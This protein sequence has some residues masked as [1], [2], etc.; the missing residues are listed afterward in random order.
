MPQDRDLALGRGAPASEAQQGLDVG[1]DSRA[2]AVGLELSNST[3]LYRV[4]GPGSGD[5]VVRLGGRS[6]GFEP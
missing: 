4:N 1:L 2:A 3:L 5:L 6:R